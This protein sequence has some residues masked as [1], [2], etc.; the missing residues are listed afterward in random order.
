M[1]Y[2]PEKVNGERRYNQWAGN[3]KGDPENKTKC[4]VEVSCSVWHSKQCNRKRGFGKGG[5]FCKQHAKTF[6]FEVE[7]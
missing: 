4:I 6:N 2:I 3:P 5:L 1:G 7:P